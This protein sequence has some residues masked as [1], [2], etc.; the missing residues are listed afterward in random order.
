MDAKTGQQIGEPLEG[1]TNAIHCVKYS[2][3]GKQ[4]VSGGDDN[5]LRIW[6]ANVSFDNRKG[7]IALLGHLWNKNSLKY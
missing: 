5:T 2:P 3:D 7:M 6:D 1:H 4:I